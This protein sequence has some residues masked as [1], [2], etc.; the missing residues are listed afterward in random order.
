MSNLFQKTPTIFNPE[1]MLIESWERF[2]AS[3]GHHSTSLGF[4]FSNP[5]SLGYLKSSIIILAIMAKVT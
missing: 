3:A 4:L 2:Y 5:F 1:R